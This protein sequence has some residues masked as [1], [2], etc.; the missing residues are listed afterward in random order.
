VS[1]AATQTQWFSTTNGRFSGILGLVAAGV[2]VVVAV[3]SGSPTWVVAGL[4]IGLVIWTVL[5]RP[6]VG[7]RGRTLVLRGT[8]ST[9]EIPLSLISSMTVR[10]VLVVWVG[11]Q[12]YVNASIGLPL[13]E[14]RPRRPS[15]SETRSDPYIEQIQELVRSHQAD[16]LRWGDE[17]GGVR[18]R[19]ARL[20]LAAIAVLTVALVVFVLV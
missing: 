9:L 20:E 16:A 17:G 8:I 14:V 15:E 4:L 3:I 5:V 2:V 13:R 11:E 6:R 19:W 1:E 7:L 18:R 10:Q 12:R